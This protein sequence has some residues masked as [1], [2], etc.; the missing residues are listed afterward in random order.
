[1]KN[2]VEQIIE[3]VIETKTGID[4]GDFIVEDLPDEEPNQCHH[5]QN[6]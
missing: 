6:S 2:P 1:M 5:L 4:I 3:D